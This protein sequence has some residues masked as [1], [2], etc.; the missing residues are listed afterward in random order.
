MSTVLLISFLMSCAEWTDSMTTELFA[1]IDETTCS[2]VA[3][4]EIG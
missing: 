4:Y 3:M 1:H 2:V